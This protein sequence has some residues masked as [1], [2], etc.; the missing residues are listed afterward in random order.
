MRQSALDAAAAAI[1][2]GPDLAEAVF[3]EAFC[4]WVLT[5]EWEKAE[6]GMRRALA[7]DP[8][9]A[10]AARSLGHVLSQRGNHDEAASMMQQAREM[11]PMDPLVHALSGQIAFQAGRYEESLA[12]ADRSLALAPLFW[13]GHMVRGQ[14]L[15]RL[16]RLD[17]AVTALTDAE[18]LGDR[19]AKVVATRAF[20]LTRLGHTSEARAI[21]EALEASSAQ[22]YVPPYAFALLHLGLGDDDLALEWLARAYESRDVHLMYVPV[23]AKWQRLRDDPTLVALLRTSGFR[24]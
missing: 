2:N 18:R 7:L 22:R 11:D 23:D 24:Q 15:E 10:D 4:A 1:A 5:W 20:A 8:Q 17:E 14:A 3:A 19:N 21:G 12:H 6:Q 16:D 13:V 9:N